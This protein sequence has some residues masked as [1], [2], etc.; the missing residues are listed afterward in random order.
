MNNGEN[1]VFILGLDCAPPELVFRRWKDDLPNL[2][3][4][5]DQGM[6]GPLKSTIPPITCPA[7]MS[8][9][10]SKDPGQLGFYG[11][12]NRRNYSY[13][14]MWIANSTAVKEP[15]MWD[16]AGEAGKKV[17]IL[18]VPQTYPPKPVNGL[19][20]TSFLTP[21]TESRYTHPPELKDE[22]A[23]VVGD[24]ILDVRNFR[25]DKKE[26][27]LEE[28]YEMTEKRFKLLGH[29]LRN[30]E[31]DLA[32][33]VEMGPDRIHHGFWKYFDEDHIAYTPGSPF[34]TA[35][36]DYYRYLDD[37]IGEI[38]PLV[39]GA[40]IL[41]VSDHGAKK[42]EGGVC[43]N[44]WLIEKGYLTLKDYP[45]EIVPLGKTEID[46]SRTRA[47]ASGGYYGRLFINVA[48][49]E[50]EGVVPEEEYESF[51]AQLIEEIEGMPDHR[52]EDLGNRAF[53]PEDVYETVN[54]IPP[55]L[56]IYFGDLD[57]R[58]VGS[59]GLKT[60]YTFENDTGP[61]DANHEQYGILIF[62]PARGEGTGPVEGLDIKDV[63]PTVLSLLGVPVPADMQGKNI[64]R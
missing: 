15:T 43:I 58:S 13:D 5:M 51:R 1:K 6:Y 61:D 24:Y 31:W 11:F 7:W 27:L 19:L 34:K 16:I 20:V 46:W 38:L 50:P 17:I 47:W 4:L 55:D 41:V 42:M 28:I 12:R 33:M 57:W 3:R 9:V 64:S 2:S 32:M 10:T 30:K 25:T 14:Q 35:I 29:L 26:E 8:M 52:G 63:S 48:G 39:E 22:I 44:E 62:R 59:V 56:I 23:S 53:K 54:N 60:V 18:G 37:R 36:F 40:S 21:G 45:E 49:R